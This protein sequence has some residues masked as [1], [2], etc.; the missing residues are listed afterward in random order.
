MRTIIVTTLVSLAALTTPVAAAA[1][2]TVPFRGTDSGTFVAL[3]PDADNVVFAQASTTGQATHLGRYSLVAH[4][5]TD[6]DD[7]RIF[8]G[9]FTL[10]AANGDTLFGTYEGTAD[11]ARFPV[12]GFDVQGPILGGTGRF[13]GATGWLRWRGYGD[14]T[15]GALSEEI[16]GWVSSV[17]SLS[18]ER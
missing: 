2:D 11:L 9:A 10:T 5:Y 7:L 15:T 1:R 14:L 4:E 3:P 8:G 12:I 16:E 6:L 13:A 18:R 17:G